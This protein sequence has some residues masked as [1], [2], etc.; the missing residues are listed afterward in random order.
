MQQRSSAAILMF[1]GV[2][3]DVTGSNSNILGKHV[4]VETFRQQIAFI[5]KSR[6][7][8]SLTRIIAAME[9]G[10]DTSG[11]AAITFDDGYRNNI[12]YAAPVLREFG[13][14]ATFFLA[15]GFIGTT[16]WLW[17]DQLEVAILG[18][19]A[20]SVNIPELGG[21][22]SLR[23]VGERKALIKNLK[24]EM[25]TRDPYENEARCNELAREL[26]GS[27]GS[28]GGNRRFL[29]WREARE[30]V[31]SGFEIGAHTVNHAILSHVTAADAET[32][33]RAS[34]ETIERETEKSC[35]HFAYPNGK[36]SDY[37]A[38]SVDI[39][40]QHFKTAATTIRGPAVLQDQYELRRY[41]VDAETDESAL[42]WMLW[43]EC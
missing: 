34:K 40:R 25:K 22:M 10:E 2:S 9:E 8:V 38:S 20:D 4:P 39:C 41:P 16:R 35:I 29:S 3:S 30:L 11:M 19:K 37:S 43:R 1:H 21:Q 12:E 28:P 18:A 13:A 24:Q 7:I 5:A 31:S 33:I 23:T 32:E 14:T 42:A 26:D 17:V 27:L 36:R 6:Q 15:T